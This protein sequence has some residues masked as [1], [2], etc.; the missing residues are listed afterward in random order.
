MDQNP[1][2]SGGTLP[3]DNTGL[4]S[5]NKPFIATTT[6]HQSPGHKL[7]TKDDGKDSETIIGTGDHKP[8]ALNSKG[9]TP[10]QWIPQQ[11]RPQ[12]KNRRPS[13]TKKDTA[14]DV[15]GKAIWHKTAPLRRPKHVVPRQKK[16]SRRLSK[17]LLLGQ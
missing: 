17:N 13:S 5:R 15:R 8:L 2:S 1:S 11:A 4:G 3:K 16:R 7:L 6:S 9:G 10:M 12:L 14:T